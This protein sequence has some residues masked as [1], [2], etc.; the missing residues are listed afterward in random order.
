M[1]QKDKGQT[2]GQPHEA[3]PVVDQTTTPA[4]AEAEVR[5]QREQEQ[6]AALDKAVEAG[7]GGP[8][9]PAEK[10]RQTRAASEAREQA[11]ADAEARAGAA[12]AEVQESSF[13]AHEGDDPVSRQ[14]REEAEK[15]AEAA[16]GPEVSE[17]DRLL[18]AAAPGGQRTA[19]TDGREGST[20]VAHTAAQA[21]P[22]LS[23]PLS[24]PVTDVENLAATDEDPDN[25]VYADEAGPRDV[26]EDTEPVKARYVDAEGNPLDWDEMFAEESGKTFVTAK[27]RVYE[28]FIFPNTVV[29]GRRLAYSA[30]RRVA[31]GE[32]ENVRSQISVHSP[33]L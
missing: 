15:A 2:A 11:K 14:R 22:P 5:E 30:G 24:P 21:R 25:R 8:A 1:A 27:V 4:E 20:K 7:V 6:Q 19:L 28:T 9:T 23:G 26:F 12:E 29:E 32:A 31:R 3:A 17:E 13:Q 16:K 10:Q 33:I 18:L